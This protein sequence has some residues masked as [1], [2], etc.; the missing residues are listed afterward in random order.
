MDI[1][2]VKTIDVVDRDD[3][4]K[5][6]AKESK[7]KLTPDVNVNKEQYLKLEEAGLL[8]TIGLYD[9]DN[10]VGFISAYTYMMPHYTS[11]AT[12]IES[13]F[14]LKEYR[15]FG[16][17]KKLLDKLVEIVNKKG[18]T[19]LFMSA[20]IGSNL[21]KVAKSFGFIATNIVYSKKIV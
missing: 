1:R 11:L 3:L 21:D 18:S 5:E 2:V 14:I 17:G 16:A 9:N 6:Y 19:M 20:G 15:K 7:G 13:Y 4:F 8:D 12:S 10:L